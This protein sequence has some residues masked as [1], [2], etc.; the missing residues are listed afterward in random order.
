MSTTVTYKGST[1]TTV[2]N[3]TRTLETA[4]K[5]LEDDITLTDVSQGSP[6]LQNKTVHPSSSDQ[7]ITA[8]A[9][10]DGLG[11]VTAKAVTTANLVAANIV[12]GVTVEV[13]DAD[14]SDRILSVTGT[15]SGGTL[16][17]LLN[18]VEYTFASEASSSNRAS[19]QLSTVPSS[20]YLIFFT[21]KEMPS[22]NPNNATG[23]SWVNVSFGSVTNRSASILR[24]N[25]TI[26]TDGTQGEYNS[27]TGVLNLGGDYGHFYAG[28][29]IDI[30]L[31]ECVS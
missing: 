28:Q 30:Y 8:D 7:S 5:Y 11:T 14:D 1:L 4:G 23:L 19:V 15:A 16:P 17:R 18:H 22:V 26:G 29:T 25:G 31:F 2:N 9:G 13:G 27:G 10:Y 3:Q 21:Q 6:T 20:R 24:A 12:S